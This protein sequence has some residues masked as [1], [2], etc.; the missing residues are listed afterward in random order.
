[1]DKRKIWKCKT[2][3]VKR[4]GVLSGVVRMAFGTSRGRIGRRKLR[5][6]WGTGTLLKTV[7]VIVFTNRVVIMKE[8]LPFCIESS[9]IFTKD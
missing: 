2:A 9:T 3:E 7:G 8:H 6:K 5:L 1:M 4:K